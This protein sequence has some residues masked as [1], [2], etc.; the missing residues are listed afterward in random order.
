MSTSVSKILLNREQIQFWDDNGYLILRQAVQPEDV[1]LALRIVDSQWSARGENDHEI[2][3]L[4]G[5]D[6]GK[7]FRL[8][9]ALAE[10]RRYV[11]KLNNLFLRV[12]EIRKVAY[13]PVVRAALIDLLEG[14]PLICNSL[15]FERGSQQP[16]HF[17]TWYMPPPVETR[18][19]AANIALEPVDAENGP[20][21]YYPGSHKIPQWRFSD[22]RLNYKADEA[23][24]MFDYLE[25]EIGKRGLQAE[26]FDGEA[27]DVF[28]WHAHLY[29]GGAAIKDL[30]RTRKSL[31]VHYWRA[32]D[33]TADRVRRDRLG[34]YLGH[35]LRGELAPV[36]GP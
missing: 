6:D 3:V 16:F 36:T 20:F 34:A 23:P 15:N 18:M 28:L 11:Y 29:H 25:D 13:A 5:P 26:T 17:D 10:H 19:I 24:R 32:G 8:H 4:S 7:T 21:I 27:G 1:A 2:D 22:G 33:M 31:V 35:T 9:N 12:P 14:E 30:T